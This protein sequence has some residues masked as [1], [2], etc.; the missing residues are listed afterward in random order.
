[1]IISE[2]KQPNIDMSNAQLAVRLTGGKQKLQPLVTL[3]LL[4]I[5]HYYKM[6]VK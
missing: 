4:L 3:K 5:E 1:M 6:A 2:L